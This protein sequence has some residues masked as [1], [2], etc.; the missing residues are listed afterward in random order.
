M[1]RLDMIE[2]YAAGARFRAPYV[3]NS[4]T[5]KAAAKALKP[6]KVEQ[7]RQDILKALQVWGPMTDDSIQ[8]RTGLSGDSERPRRIS[9]L[10]DGLIA[11]VAKKSAHAAGS[12]LWSGGL[13]E[14]NEHD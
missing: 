7:C 13:C 3:R 9:L 5:S 1:N 8:D 6:G 14:R 11:T 4:A 2:Q 12:W 10:K